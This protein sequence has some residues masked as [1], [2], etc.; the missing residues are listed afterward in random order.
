MEWDGVEWWIASTEHENEKDIEV[1]EWNC[2]K[3]SYV[4]VQSHSSVLD[5]ISTDLILPDSHTH[6]RTFQTDWLAKRNIQRNVIPCTKS[7]TSAMVADGWLFSPFVRCL[8]FRTHKA[9]NIATTKV[10]L[11]QWM[12]RVHLI[13]TKARAQFAW[14]IKWLR[15]IS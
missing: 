12:N 2:K 4:L 3:W 9:Q 14:I 13:I 7:L 5:S 6:A 8:S 15:E 1:W 11:S 10:I